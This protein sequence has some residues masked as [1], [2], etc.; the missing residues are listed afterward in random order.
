MLIDQSIQ[1]LG[2]MSL[3]RT[4]L[5]RVPLPSLPVPLEHSS[6]F[7]KSQETALFEAS[8]TQWGFF[9]HERWVTSEAN[10]VLNAS[11]AKQEAA[12]QTHANA[13][14]SSEQHCALLELPAELRN[15]IY[16][17]TLIDGELCT[18]IAE[19]EYSE[20]GLLQTCRQIR[21]EASP[22]FHNRWFWLEAPNLEPC[23]QLAHRLWT[24]VPPHDIIISH[25]GTLKFSVL[26]IWLKWT[27][28]CGLRPGAFVSDNDE[29][30]FAVRKLFEIAEE[31]SGH[32]WTTTE[33][34]LELTR[35]CL[36]AESYTFDD[37]NE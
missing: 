9:K 34:I 8:S 22:I 35:E 23:P 18:S 17:Y 25:R 28:R 24:K 3:F 14:D 12:T 7:S 36:N 13:M 26:K 33:R 27:H 1:S 19:N 21:G 4:F 29:C 6:K 16:A 31:M 30:E 5:S 11:N 2:H 10:S 37:E 20:P 15:T 32:S